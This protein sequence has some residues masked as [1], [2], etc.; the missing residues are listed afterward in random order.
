MG[1]TIQFR[2]GTILFLAAAVLAY[3]DE[4]QPENSTKAAAVDTTA[5]TEPTHPELQR[6]NPLY[7]LSRSD[8]LDLNFPLTPEFNQSVTIRP[9]GYITLLG[10]GDLHVEGQTIPQVTESLR[11][12]YAKRL[13]DPIITVQLKDFEKP[14]FVVGGEVG[15][16]GKYELRGDTTVIQAVQIAGGF[17]PGAKHSQVWLFRR[18]SNEWV[19]TQKIDVKRM[20]HAGN[21]QEDADLHPGDMV[22]VP[23]S[24]FETFKRF[25]PTTSLA[26][27]AP[28]L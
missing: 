22:Y 27:Y 17:T 4:S 16:P 25:L 3:A 6:R 13:H 8:V 26:L 21:L 14:Y 7:Q 12:A 18:V 11:A 24:A 9:D 20:L 5:Q 23:K 19:E 2:F 10:A 28:F 1:H 15:H